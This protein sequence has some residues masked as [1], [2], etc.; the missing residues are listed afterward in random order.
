TEA[1]RGIYDLVVLFAQSRTASVTASENVRSRAAHATFSARCASAGRS[2]LIVLVSLSLLISMTSTHLH[3]P[4]VD[5]RQA[6][7]AKLIM[8]A[9]RRS[10]PVVNETRRRR[11]RPPRD[12]SPQ[13]SAGRQAF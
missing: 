9:V 10:V 11:G 1:G 7:S 8:A 4:F 13:A 3:Y 5:H 2:T 6:R 12:P